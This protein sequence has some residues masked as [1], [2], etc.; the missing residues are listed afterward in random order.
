MEE[1]AD[2]DEAEGVLGI[3]DV[4]LE[5]FDRLDDRL[6]GNDGRIPT[7]FRDIDALIGGLFPCELIVI[8]GRSSMGKTALMMDV[9]R[10][11]AIQGVP[12]LMIS[13]EM[14]RVEVAQRMLC[15]QGRVDH[16]KF[17]SDFVRKDDREQLISAS[18]ALGRAPLFVDDKR[19]QTIHDIVATARRLKQQVN[20][21]LL[22]ID[23]LQL[24]SPDG[25]ND[26]L[27]EQLAKIVRELHCLAWELKIPILCCSQLNRLPLSDTGDLRPKLHHLRQSGAIEDTADVVMFIHREEYYHTR[28]EAREKGISGVADVIVAKQRNGPTGEVKL[29]W[30]DTHTCFE[31]YAQK[32]YE[33]FMDFREQF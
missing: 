25:P 27:H 16:S 9:A 33:E 3:H 7:G 15:A 23:F 22:A 6:G 21:G 29:G 24:I 20:L 12:T 14:T 10:N 26:N 31:N 30:L 8:A 11:A 4:L 2:R 5:T 28:E 32:S 13:L 1:Q 19:R 18:V 17:R